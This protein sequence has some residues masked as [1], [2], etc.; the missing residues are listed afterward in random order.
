MNLIFNLVRSSFIFKTYDKQAV[1]INPRFTIR[2]FFDSLQY[3]IG[4]RSSSKQ[5]VRYFGKG[6]FITLKHLRENKN[7]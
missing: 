2:C 6:K 4:I 3:G 1:I 7:I 5:V